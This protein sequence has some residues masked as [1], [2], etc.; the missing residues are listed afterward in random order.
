[1]ALP[2]AWK[3]RREM[4]RTRDTLQT[5]VARLIYEPLR[6]VVYDRRT[7]RLQTVTQGAVPL[8]DRVAVFVIFQPKGL[9]ASVHLTLDHLRE[10]G[11]SVLLV[12]NGPLVA[13]DRQALAAK[14]GVV[15]ERPN[16]GYD[17]GGYRDG[18]RHLWA[19]RHE[20]TRLVLLN[21]STWFP[22]R[23]TDNSLARMEALGADLAGHV[24]KNEDRSRGRQDHLESHLLMISQGF[25][26]SAEFRQYWSRY[27]MSDHRTTTIAKGEKGFSQLA[28]STRH[29]VS[30]LM[31][32]DWL[33][34]TLDELDDASLLRVLDETIDDVP[35]RR[36]NAAAFRA[37]AASGEPWR[38][39]Y[40][41]W[42]RDAL[43]NTVS[44]VL[45]SAFIMPALVYGGM[46]FAKK[47]NDIRF[48]LARRKV[49]ELEAKG[50]IAPLD[51]VVRAEISAAVAAWTTPGN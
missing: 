8:T 39:G 14:C 1:M 21:D 12:S 18:I 29:R 49:L 51:A 17:F 50:V 5:T 36:Q 6:K 25:L 31:G 34:S 32:R 47:A 26:R 35:G 24:F 43:S 23:R 9:P 11:F 38:Q 2:P 20:M 4:A 16:V 30:A 13:A 37:A 48:H 15:L 7:H 42:A 33:I 44:F 40:L 3:V 41:D 45:S 22:L 46:G 10:N 27:R 28:L 19:L